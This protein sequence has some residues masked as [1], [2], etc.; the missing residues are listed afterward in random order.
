LIDG[1]SR[2]AAGSAIENRDPT[3]E[4][5]TEPGGRL[6]CAHTGR[7]LHSTALFG[8]RR[9]ITIRHREEACQLRVTRS[10]KL[11]L[12]K[13]SGQSPTAAGIIG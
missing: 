8:G 10:N 7:E 9:E 5:S 2:S 12:T 1:Q 6:D 3:T 11:I 13:S 4:G